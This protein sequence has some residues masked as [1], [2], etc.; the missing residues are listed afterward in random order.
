MSVP[1]IKTGRPNEAQLSGREL[2]AM[3][4]TAVKSAT[5]LKAKDRARLATQTAEAQSLVLQL[6]QAVYE[7][8]RLRRCI[9]SRHYCP[10]EQYA[11]FLN[12]LLDLAQPIVELEPLFSRALGP[13]A[14]AKHDLLVTLPP[15]ESDDSTEGEGLRTNLDTPLPSTELKID[16]TEDDDL[17][18]FPLGRMVGFA[19]GPTPREVE[20]ALHSIQILS[21]E[22]E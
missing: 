16:E 18:T 9:S 10:D 2:Q 19:N 5:G 1:R 21:E 20:R 11:G 13:L 12:R 4:R 15:A 17:D 8:K 3:R 22:E 6:R 14:G 7:L